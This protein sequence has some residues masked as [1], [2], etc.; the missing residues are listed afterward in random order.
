MRGTGRLLI[1]ESKKN[2]IRESRRS[3]YLSSI[4]SAATLAP[5]GVEVDTSIRCRRRPD[6][7]LCHGLIRLRLHEN[8][9]ELVWWCPV[10]RDKGVIRNWKGIPWNLSHTS[11]TDFISGSDFCEILLEE[12]EYKLLSEIAILEPKAKKIVQSASIIEGGV[13]LIGA[14]SAMDE[15][16]KYIAFEANHELKLRRQQ[17]LNHLFDKINHCVLGKW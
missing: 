6:R 15:L 2:N 1:P 16:M 11:H 5:P 14:S 4:V 9:A 12:Q 13:I 3:E 10:C 8:P 7:K 17:A